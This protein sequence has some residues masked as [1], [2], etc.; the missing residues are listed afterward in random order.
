MEI[1]PCKITMICIHHTAGN[2]ANTQKVREEHMGF[3]NF[4]GDIGY[5]AVIE[6]NGI[7]GTGRDIKYS[8]AH[9]PGKCPDGSGYTMNQRSYAISHIGNFM[10]E[11]M[12]D[13]QFFASVKH[14][15]EKCKEFGIVP[16]TSTIRQHK[17]DYATDCPG[18]NFPYDRYVKEVINLYN[19][20][21]KGV[22]DVLDVA[23]LLFSKEDYWSG[24]DVA[25]KNGNCA[26]FIRPTDKS[27]P[28]NA[29]NSKKLI[30]IGGSKTGHLNEILLS[31]NT[32]YDTAQKVSKYLLGK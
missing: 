28:K 16:S 31:G 7:I 32:K 14:C 18:D 25:E 22:D 2:E 10:K 15:A 5:N 8:G 11:T 30:T 26:I 29:M 20:N 27:V 12:N 1:R 21:N 3:P 24:T 4:W 19:N 9:N 17:S 23:V 13:V 6:K